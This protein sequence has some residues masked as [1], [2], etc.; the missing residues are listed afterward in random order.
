MHGGGGCVAG[1][2]CVVEGDV[3]E[4]RPLKHAVLLECIL[5]SYFFKVLDP[6]LISEYFAKTSDWQVTQDS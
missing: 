4:R 1:C 5:I 2:V 3:G 6:L